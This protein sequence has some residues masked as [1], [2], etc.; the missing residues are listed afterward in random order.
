[1]ACTASVIGLEPRNVLASKQNEKEKPPEAWKAAGDLRKISPRDVNSKRNY[2]PNG[3]DRL[4]LINPN[5]GTVRKFVLI[6]RRELDLCKWIRH[7]S[8]KTRK[9]MDG[10]GEMRKKISSGRAQEVMLRHETRKKRRSATPANDE[11]ARRRP[12][13]VAIK[14]KHNLY[15]NS[16][17][18]VHSAPEPAGAYRDARIK[19]SRAEAFTQFSRSNAERSGTMA[20]AT[21]L[22]TLYRSPSQMSSKRAGEV[23]AST[24]RSKEHNFASSRSSSE[25][26]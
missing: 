12:A 23:F 6:K 11:R 2:R 25:P 4:E 13:R 7:C 8:R 16:V 19:S 10:R 22:F 17:A 1:M 18:P 24:K 15:A 14:S 26:K 9:V 20:A 3:S 5:R 21:A